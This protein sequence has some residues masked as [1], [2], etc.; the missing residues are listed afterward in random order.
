[1][2]SKENKKYIVNL[3]I[4][5]KGEF[6]K[7]IQL[8]ISNK[9]NKKE[10]KK[11]HNKRKNIISGGFFGWDN[12]KWFFREIF[13]I[14]SSEKSYFSKK[15][16]ESSF[17]FLIGQGGMILYLYTHYKTLTISDFLL[18][19]AVEFVI[20]GYYV[21]QIQ[22]QKKE[23]GYYSVNAELKAEYKEDDESVDESTPEDD[24]KDYSNEIK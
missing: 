2:E 1:M 7:T 13:K 6:N 14:Y 20:A 10:V 23:S 17:A 9:T 16:I 3:N 15:R 22:K 11:T 8:N 5:E 19:A 18:W 4:P 21:S 24:T 12:I